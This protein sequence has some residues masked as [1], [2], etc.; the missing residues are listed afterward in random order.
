MSIAHDDE[1]AYRYE[2]KINEYE[3]EI[4]WQDDLDCDLELSG[5]HK[6]VLRQVRKIIKRLR[7]DLDEPVH[8]YIS[9]ISNR[10]GL[11]ESTVRRLL[12]QLAEYG[13]ITKQ[14]K[15]K[16]VGSEIRNELWISLAEHIRS[17][18]AII[19]VPSR[20]HGGDRRCEKCGS[21]NIDVL[22]VYACRDCGHI[23]RTDTAY[24]E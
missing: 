15:R 14:V 22:T 10:T 5:N 6:L 20:N 3:K 24:S 16:R 2:L 8:I 23:H 18:A 13:L 12:T 7:Y 11:E 9:E 17:N 19:S 21:K 4:K 1:L